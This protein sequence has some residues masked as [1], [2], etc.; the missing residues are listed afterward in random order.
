MV[1]WLSTVTKVL[2]LVTDVVSKAL[3]AFTSRKTDKSSDV[4]PQQIAELQ[5]ASTQNAADLKLLAEQLKRTVEAVD[6]GATNLERELQQIRQS[7]ERTEQ[8]S[9][10]LRQQVHALEQRVAN[11]YRLCVAALAMALVALGVG[12]LILSR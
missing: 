6:E 7:F 12:V 5:G 10:S 4:V 11:S 3:P 9:A 8:A 2:P 1:A